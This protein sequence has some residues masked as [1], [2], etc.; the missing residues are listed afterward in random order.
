MV[1]ER[2]LVLDFNEVDNMT[3]VC[4]ENSSYR[5]GEYPELE[6][7]KVYKV[8]HIGV[9]RSK[10]DLLLEGFG[11]KDYNSTCFDLYENGEPLGQA[12]TRDFRFLAPY[13][14]ERLKLLNPARY[15]ECEIGVSI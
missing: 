1:D 15:A 5:R 13:L 11:Y 3:A 8:T 14:K 10:T 12:Y 9:F 6:V 2:R 7:G 4:R